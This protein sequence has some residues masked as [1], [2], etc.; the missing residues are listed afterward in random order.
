MKIARAPNIP[1]S[2]RALVS[3]ISKRRLPKRPAAGTIPPAKS[4]MHDAEWLIGG[5]YTFA[6]RQDVHA[7]FLFIRVAPDAAA[8]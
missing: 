4:N 5:L 1:V 2:T 7:E 3:K 6:S 8:G